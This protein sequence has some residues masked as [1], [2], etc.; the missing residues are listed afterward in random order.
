MPGNTVTYVAEGVRGVRR[1]GANSSASSLVVQPRRDGRWEIIKSGAP[2][3][4]A[5]LDTRSDAVDR[6]RCLASARGIGTVYVREPIR[7][8][9]GRGDEATGEPCGRTCVYCCGPETD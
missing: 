4:S 5:V 9:A 8:A 7:G 3:A 2:R 1:S 6:A